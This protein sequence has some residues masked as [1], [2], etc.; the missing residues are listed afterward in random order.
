MDNLKIT[1]SIEEIMSSQKRVDEL[2]L[3]IGDYVFA[4]KYSDADPN[5]RWFVGTIDLIANTSKP[6]IL[7]NDTGGLK[8][9][10]AQRITAEEGEFILERFKNFRN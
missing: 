7:F 2:S 5:D 3:S 4:T 1:R 10:Y 9:F 8:Y 6:H